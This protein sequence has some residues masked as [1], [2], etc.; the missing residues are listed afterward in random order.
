[1]NEPLSKTL[2]L[3]GIFRTI[4]NIVK[5]DCVIQGCNYT[6]LRILIFLWEKEQEEE[7]Y[8]GCK[9]LAQKMMMSPQSFS[10]FLRGLEKKEWIKKIHSTFNLKNVYVQLTD[11]AKNILKDNYNM[12]LY[13]TEN[14]IKKM[15]AED[16]DVLI[17]KMKKLYETIEKEIKKC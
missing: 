14:V 4:S 15:G 11:K 16:V 10:R 12:I 7:K 9:E 3:L 2:E 1:M 6:E 5:K 13:S 8:Y 17:E